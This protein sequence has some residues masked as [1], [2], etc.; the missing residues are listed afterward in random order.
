MGMSSHVIGIRP[1]DATWN[2]MKAVYDACIAAKVKIP[3]EVS[4][5]LGDGD[6]LD[7]KGVVVSLTSCTTT[8]S[9]EFHEG[10]EVDLRKIPAGVT[11]IRFYNSY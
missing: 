8:Y 5:Y 6:R 10:F 7:P 4:D 11:I 3:E 1:P 9:A 2:K